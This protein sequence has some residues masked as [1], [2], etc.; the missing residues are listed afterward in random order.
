MENIYFLLFALLICWHFYHHRK[1]A[2]LAHKAALQYCDQ[3][4]L[5]FIAV[6]RK[7]ARI[8]FSKRY[9]I[10][11]RMIFQMEFSGDGESSNTGTIEIEAGRVKT[12]QLPVYRVH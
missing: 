2:E 4:N 5:Q 6:A 9:G 8:G 12:I 10:Y 7:K 3:H 11:W 1:L